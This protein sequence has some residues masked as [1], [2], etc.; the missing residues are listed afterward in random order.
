MATLDADGPL[1]SI[2]GGGHP[3]GGGGRGGYVVHEGARGPAPARVGGCAHVRRRGGGEVSGG[4]DGQGG[5]GPRCDERHEDGDHRLRPRL[6]H[7][8]AGSVAGEPTSRVAGQAMKDERSTRYARRMS[9]RF[10][11][12]VLRANDGEEKTGLAES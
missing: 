6:R 10:L 8:H 7:A 2:A 1:H 9:L 4:R 3:G 12:A 5:R 11:I